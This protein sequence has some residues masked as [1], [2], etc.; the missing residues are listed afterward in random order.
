MAMQAV[1]AKPKATVRRSKGMRSTKP[2][3][4]VPSGLCPAA[5]MRK[6]NSRIPASSVTP[7]VTMAVSLYA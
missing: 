4:T 5:A 3:R 2:P 6:T 1:T 7:K